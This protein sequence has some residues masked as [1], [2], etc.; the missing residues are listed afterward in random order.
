MLGN[1]RMECSNRVAYRV[2]SVISLYLFVNT[3]ELK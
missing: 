3:L 2:E 1:V